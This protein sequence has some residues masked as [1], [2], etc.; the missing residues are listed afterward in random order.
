MSSSDEEVQVQAPLRDVMGPLG[1]PAGVT[2]NPRKSAMF[3]A[4]L[5]VVPYAIGSGFAFAIYKFWENSAYVAK[6][7]TIRGADV[8]VNDVYI[9]VV[10]MAV[11]STWL[12][13]CPMYFKAKVM[14]G[15]SGNLRA[16]MTISKVNAQSVVH[17]GGKFP[18]V[19]L[20]DEGAI[21]EYNRANR[22]MLHFVENSAAVLL[23]IP[24]AG[25]V[26]PRPTLILT[27]IYAIGRVMHQQGY[28]KG[29]GKHAPGFML[30]MLSEKTLVGLVLMAAVC[31]GTPAATA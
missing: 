31:P 26:F 4:A 28:V 23:S 5:T 18:Y 15:A 30:V 8:N 7:D 14:T 21:G 11:L 25:F 22:S 24:A 20:E 19:V 16:N 29:Y 27:C 1:M 12:N 13:M 9:A 10:V 17:A 6:I 2:F 3:C